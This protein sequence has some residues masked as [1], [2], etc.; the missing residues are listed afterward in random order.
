MWK[1]IRRNTVRLH[2]SIHR[3]KSGMFFCVH[4]KRKKEKSYNMV[5]IRREQTDIWHLKKKLFELHVPQIADT[6]CIIKVYLVMMILVDLKYF[7]IHHRAR[8]MIMIN[9]EKDLIDDQNER[10]MLLE[11]IEYYLDIF[12]WEICWITWW[13]FWSIHWRMNYISLD[14]LNLS[15]ATIRIRFLWFSVFEKA[16]L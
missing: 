5:Y 3:Q 2:H 12:P 16:W 14:L 15:E 8:R 1:V 13:R 10:W 11:S 4:K 6:Q 7:V 9:Q